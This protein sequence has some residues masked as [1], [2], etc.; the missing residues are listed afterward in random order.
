MTATHDHPCCETCIDLE[1]DLNR[2]Q[3]ALR[4]AREALGPE[5]DR[6]DLAEAIESLKA[7][8]AHWKGVA[9]MSTP[10]PDLPE[11]LVAYPGLAD[12][13]Y[14]ALGEYV[15]KLP[16]GLGGWRRRFHRGDG[17]WLVNNNNAEAAFTNFYVVSRVPEPR[18][19]WWEA[20]RDNMTL[21]ESGMWCDTTSLDPDTGVRMVGQTGFAD[22]D[23]IV[24]D[25]GTVA[26]VKRVKL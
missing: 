25:D 24:A 6:E 15:R 14:L 20:L 12:G 5:W 22:D 18:V 11:G 8:V 2:V 1:R 3:G 9:L 17:G 26:A 23:V 7:Q 10:D 21:L 4:D 16:A 19:P 13:E